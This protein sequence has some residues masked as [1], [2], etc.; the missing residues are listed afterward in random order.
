MSSIADRLRSYLRLLIAAALLFIVPFVG[1]MSRVAAMG[2][3]SMH[4]QQIDSAAVDCATACARAVHVLPT[5]VVVT[6]SKTRTPDPKPQEI[7]PYHVQFQAMSVPKKLSPA[8]MYGSM[9]SRPPDRVKLSGH[10][11]F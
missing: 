5:T 8:A 10:F 1:S 4:M 9:P 11:L 2:D 6:E 7:V 3:H